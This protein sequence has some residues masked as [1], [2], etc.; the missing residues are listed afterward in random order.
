MISTAVKWGGGKE[1]E[2]SEDVEKEQMN[3][4]MRHWTK[5]AAEEGKGDDR[6]TRGKAVGEDDVVRRSR[7]GCRS[8]PVSGRAKKEDAAR[9]ATI[10]SRTEAVR[11]LRVRARPRDRPPGRRR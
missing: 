4:V 7:A 1:K 5:M 2:G 8:E 9:D 6:A 3:T 10:N 11:L